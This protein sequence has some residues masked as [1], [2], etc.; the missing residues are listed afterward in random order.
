MY[1]SSALHTTFMYVALRA[2]RANEGGTTDLPDYSETVPREGC[3]KLKLQLNTTPPQ[4]LIHFVE[5]CRQ[6]HYSIYCLE[7]VTGHLSWNNFH[8]ESLRRPDYH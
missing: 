1:L 8:V 5:R 6:V 7:S 2:W 3:L 4:W